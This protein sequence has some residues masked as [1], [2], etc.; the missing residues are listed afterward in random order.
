VASTST[1]QLT[2]PRVVLVAP[3]TR[4]IGGQARQAEV[5]RTQLERD[6]IAHVTFV[7][8]DRELPAVIRRIPLIRTALNIVAF[9][10]ALVRALRGANVVHSFSA[11]YASYLMHPLPAL[12]LGRI[13][14]K[15]T[16]LHYHSGEAEDHLQRS[17]LAVWSIGRFADI[18]VVPTPYLR[19]VFNRFGLASIEIANFVDMDGIPYRERVGAGARVLANRAFEPLYN[20]ACVLRAFR[21]IQEVRPDASLVLAG[22]GSLAEA[23]RT[24][25]ESLHLKQVEFVGGLDA[26]KMSRAYDAADVYIN[27]SNIDNMPVSLVECGAAGLPVVSTNAGGIPF[28]VTHGESALLAE[29]DDDRTL[30]M[31]VL[32]LLA[33]PELSVTL[34][35]RHREHVVA[36][37]AWANVADRWRQV[38]SGRVPEELNSA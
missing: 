3:S 27:A 33:E 19:G 9:V 17:A 30:A 25:V 20:V 23:L 13:A 26:G 36:R 28:M 18:V 8:I 35:R 31:H 10:L 24:Q 11:S 5:L 14:G 37:Y 1:V 2:P 22:Q 15:R 6:G 16:V 21:R 38:Y 32:R 4:M 29:L 12:I 34:A 7:A